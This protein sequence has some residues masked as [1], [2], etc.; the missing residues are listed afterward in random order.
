MSH[1]LIKKK[2]QQK[3]HCLLILNEREVNTSHIKYLIFNYL[4]KSVFKS[5]VVYH[6]L[7]CTEFRN[8]LKGYRGL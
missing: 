8:S 6:I 7:T 3:I 1:L 2:Q 4:N 5:A